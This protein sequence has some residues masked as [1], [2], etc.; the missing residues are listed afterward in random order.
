MR[1]IK[2]YTG[3]GPRRT[4]GNFVVVTKDGVRIAAFAYAE[5]ARDFARRGHAYKH[6]GASDTPDMLENAMRFSDGTKIAA[7]HGG[8]DVE[9]EEVA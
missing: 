5:D 8:G 3:T 1:I 7:D 2:D 9:E 4:T 6:H